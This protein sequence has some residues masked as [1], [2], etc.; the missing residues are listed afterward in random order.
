MAGPGLQGDEDEGSSDGASEGEQGGAWGA[1][2]PLE[3]SQEAAALF[4]MLACV[5]PLW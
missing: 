4:G 1:G 5:P 2:T 3:P